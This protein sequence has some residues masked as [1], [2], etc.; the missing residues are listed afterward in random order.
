MQPAVDSFQA[1]ARSS[2]WRWRTLHFTRRDGEA[3]VEAWVRRPGELLVRRPGRG[4]HYER[5]APAGASVFVASA[6]M[7]PDATPP[8]PPRLRL[9]HEV[10]PPLRPD[11]L[12]AER[13]DVGLIEYGDPMYEN[14]TWVAMLDPVELSHNVAVDRVQRDQRRGRE[15]WRARLRAQPG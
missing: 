13:P 6:S 15:T 5:E 2:P 1:L 9:P 3:A 10:R 8:P 14:Y 11:G 4:D 12:V 7:D